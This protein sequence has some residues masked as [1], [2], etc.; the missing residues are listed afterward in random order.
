MLQIFVF[1]RANYNLVVACLIA[2]S[3]TKW[4]VY[5][6][7]LYP[8]MTLEPHKFP[9]QTHKCEFEFYCWSYFLFSKNGIIEFAGKLLVMFYDQQ[10]FEL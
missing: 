10:H 9:L 5:V 4:L 6:V 1:V 3:Y 2:T 7:S 8:E